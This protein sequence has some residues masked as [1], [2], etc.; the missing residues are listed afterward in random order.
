M[1]EFRTTLEQMQNASNML[2][3]TDVTWSYGGESGQGGGQGST[4][5]QNHD[6]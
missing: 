3:Q 5:Q 4:W 1:G 2:D 6:C